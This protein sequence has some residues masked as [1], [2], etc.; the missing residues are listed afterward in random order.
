MTT[1]G[2][3]QGTDPEL[4]DLVP[5]AV[6]QPPA[7]VVRANE[8]GR[9]VLEVREPG[10]YQWTTKSGH[11]RSVHGERSANAGSGYRA[12][13]SALRTRLGCLVGRHVRATHARGATTADPGVKYFSGDGHLQE[14]AE[15]TDEVLSVRDRRL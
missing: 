1:A 11:A 3:C 15:I 9:A 8:Q 12:V 5:A 14:D 13:G 4:I 10:D 6:L 7:A 2:T